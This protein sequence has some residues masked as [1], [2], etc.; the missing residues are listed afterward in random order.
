MKK[1]TNS[2]HGDEAS[3]FLFCARTSRQHLPS[4]FIPLVLLQAIL[5]LFLF[6]ARAVQSYHTQQHAYETHTN[7]RQ[8]QSRASPTVP[9]Y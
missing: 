9:T 4:H 2:L 7:T 1:K 8:P 3:T 6:I 5:I